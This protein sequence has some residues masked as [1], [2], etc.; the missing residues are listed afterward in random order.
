M[1]KINSTLKG[2]LS[3]NNVKTGATSAIVKTQEFDEFIEED[4]EVVADKKTFTYGQ[5]CLVTMKKVDAEKVKDVQFRGVS[6]LT[7]VNKRKAKIF[8][9]V[10]KHYWDLQHQTKDKFLKTDQHWQ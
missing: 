8:E 3:V 10:I 6:G 7:E 5:T 4:A 1:I 9:E 2:I